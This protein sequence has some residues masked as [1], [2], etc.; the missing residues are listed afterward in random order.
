MFPTGLILHAHKVT[1]CNDLFSIAPILHVQ[2]VKEVHLRTHFWVKWG[3]FHSFKCWGC[4]IWACSEMHLW[5]PETLVT[6]RCGKLAPLRVR[7]VIPLETWM[8]ALR[9]SPSFF[10]KK[11]PI[12]TKESLLFLRYILKRKLL[13]HN[14]FSA[15]TSWPFLYLCLI[16]S[17][18]F[19]PTLL[20]VP[21]YVSVL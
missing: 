10:L 3:V 5:N 13:V 8:G 6:F 4:V 11:A 1:A 18:C 19:C 20:S 2:K 16:L 7:K 9:I 21:L 15:S 14:L 17:L 12:S